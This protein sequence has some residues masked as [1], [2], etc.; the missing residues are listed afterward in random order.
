MSRGNESGQGRATG[1]GQNPEGRQGGTGTGRTSSTPA[2]QGATRSVSAG[3]TP[4][5]GRPVGDDRGPAHEGRSEPRSQG[6]NLVDELG[7]RLPEARRFA[8]E[9]VESSAEL[10]RGNP[11][12]ALLA[13]FGAGFAVGLVIAALLP[14]RRRPRAWYDH[15]ALEGLKRVPEHLREVPGTAREWSGAAAHRLASAFG[16]D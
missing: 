10:V 9:A 5:S 1:Q 7:R 3:T 12:V 16:R 4:S 13:G 6:G 8:S 2:G 15:P 11:G 14:E